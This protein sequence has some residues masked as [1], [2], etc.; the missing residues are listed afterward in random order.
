MP[1]M[2]E[3]PVDSSVEGL[4]PVETSPTTILT[5]ITTIT[6][7]EIITMKI[8]TFILAMET[9]WTTVEDRVIAEAIREVLEWIR[10]ITTSMI[11]TPTYAWTV[12]VA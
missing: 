11:E 7:A 5:T 8:A 3:D 1:Q 6:K 10:T 12:V 9:S 2:F 4:E